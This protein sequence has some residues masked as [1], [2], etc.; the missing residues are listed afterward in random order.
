MI[1]RDAPPARHISPTRGA[2]SGCSAYYKGTALTN[3]ERGKRS[4]VLTLGPGPLGLQVNYRLRAA[5]HLGVESVRL[6]IYKSPSQ[7]RRVVIGAGK[8]SLDR[9]MRCMQVDTVYCVELQ[10]RSKDKYI[11]SLDAI[12][13]IRGITSPLGCSMVLRT[14][15]CRRTYSGW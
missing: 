8:I 13:A 9:L 12:R 11:L 3:T 7:Q 14:V 10:T 4:T 5:S 6:K 15:R 1:D 2:E